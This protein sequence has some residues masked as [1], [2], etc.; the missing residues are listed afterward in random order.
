[1]FKIF[2]K[3]M[4][5]LKDWTFIVATKDEDNIDLYSDFEDISGI[6][7]RLFTPFANGRVNIIN[8]KIVRRF[9]LHNDD[10]TKTIRCVSFDTQTV[11]YIEQ[12]YRKG[13]APYPDFDEV[14][15]ILK[16]HKFAFDH[17]PYTMENLMFHPERKASVEKTLFAYEMLCGANSG[18]K[19]RCWLRAKSVASLYGRKRISFPFRVKNVYKLVYLSLLN[20]SYIQLAH[21]KWP[22]EK[23]M[24]AFLEFIENEICQLMQP[25][26]NLA[27]LYFTDG[28]AS[29]FFGKVHCGNKNILEQ[30]KNIAWDLMHLRFMDYSC[31]MFNAKKADALIPYFFTYDQRLQKVRKC[32]ELQTLAINTCNHAVIP[33][34][35]THDGIKDKVMNHCTFER[36]QER[37]SKSVDVDKLIDTYEK[38]IL[39]LV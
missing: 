12:Y 23:K 25:E 1:M 4:D 11:S 34:Y 6:R 32:Y 10:R 30:L 35:V 8:D 14:L 16:G 15:R 39:T 24:D 3:Y 18:N 38:K 22:R 28:S 13:E 17:F 36:Y 20:M 2:W 33:I 31:T 9:F 7:E 37:T 26:L 19:M 29:G 27:N 5:I 21:N